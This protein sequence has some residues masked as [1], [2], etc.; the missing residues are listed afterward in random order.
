MPSVTGIPC[1]KQSGPDSCVNSCYPALDRRLS[2]Q[3][4]AHVNP[5]AP[6]ASPASRRFADPGGQRRRAAR[7]RLIAVATMAAFAIAAAII[8]YNDGLFLVRL[9]G[10]GGRLAYLYPLLPDGLIVISWT[11]MYE[12]G[13]TGVPRPAWA[14]AG[15]ALGAC[16]TVSM[17]V[18]AGVMHNGLAA[19]VDG[20]VPVVFFV[21]LEILVGILRRRGAATGAPPVAGQPETAWTP[22]TEEALRALLAS[23]SI[24][25]LAEV[26]GIPKSRVE[27][28]RQQLAG[29]VAGPAPA[30]PLNGSAP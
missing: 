23:A 9:A 13:L 5:K 8:S 20:V 4:E 22:T 18:A 10:I 29:P 19:L 17:N 7:V 16:L 21:A 1:Q 3:E 2:Y 30:S 25:G 14:T 24:R 15:I 6:P 11:S 12:A 26:L 27:T 28:W